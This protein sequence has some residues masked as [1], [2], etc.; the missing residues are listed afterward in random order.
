VL[1]K[2]KETLLLTVSASENIDALNRSV[3]DSRD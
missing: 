3:I 2:F 1:E